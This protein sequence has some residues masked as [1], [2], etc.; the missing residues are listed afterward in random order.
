MRLL[1]DGEAGRVTISPGAA[2]LE[3]FSKSS[4]N[5]Q[6]A[7][8]AMAADEVLP[9][10]TRDG[11][12]IS[13]LANIGRPEEVEQIGVHH[14]VGVGFFE[15]SSVLESHECPSFQTQCDITPRRRRP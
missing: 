14:L 5:Y 13:L 12:G 2:E 9:C 7:T 10:L 15:R 6:R 8:A 11:I 1:V 4:E 3:E